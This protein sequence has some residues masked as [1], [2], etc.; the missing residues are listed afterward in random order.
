MSGG[1]RSA[2]PIVAGRRP[3]RPRAV[4]RDPSTGEPLVEVGQATE[5]DV[6]DA[7]AAAR[8]A[9][10]ALE[11]LAP[12]R[13]GAALGQAA[14]ALERQVE[15]W[16]RDMAEEMGKP[17]REATAEC[18]RA[19]EILRFHAQQVAAPLGERYAATAPGSAIYTL[20]QPLGTVA[21]IAPWNFPAAIPA[22][23]LAPALA[24]GN[25]T[26]LKLSDAGALTGLRL[27]EAL[28]E[29]GLPEGAVN[30]VLGEDPRIGRALVA[31]PDVDAVSF[32]GSTRVGRE[33]VGVA[34]ARGARV[35]AEMGGHAPLVVMEDAELPDAVEAAVMGA[36][37]S[38][39]QKCTSTRRAY[40]AA[41]S[42]EEFVER[43]VE[44]ASSLVAGPAC[45]PETT[46]GPLVDSAARDRVLGAVE[47][48]GRE[49]QLRFGGDVPSEPSTT[50]GAYLT[51]AIVTDL[52]EDA[53]LATREVFGPVLAVWPFERDED[54]VALANRTEYGLAA[55]IFTNDL[56]V[57]DRFA[58]RVR[59]GMVH[60]NSQTAG[61]DPHVPFGGH[62]ASGYGPR[63]QGREAHTFYTEER[64][65]YVD[66]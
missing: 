22:W 40:V 52:P 15:D 46:L 33:V 44:R 2:D 17:V 60:V 47:E 59:A 4:R 48:A 43:L 54:P 45:D 14:A 62:A 53:P 63:E 8:D 42:Y 20:R 55:S 28:L 37:A 61:A 50:A 35:Q 36:F 66:A 41:S 64:T 32:T 29:T 26:V 25:A 12:A 24:A 6:A 49:G 34:S 51:P 1:L 65:V 38:A 21:L 39:G 16:A 58:R 57:A 31:H 23:K 10:A 56:G 3:D 27:V 19:V 11:E 18:R 9:A 5:A 13:R 30:V 7:V